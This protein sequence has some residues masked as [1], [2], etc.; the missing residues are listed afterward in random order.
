VILKQQHPIHDVQREMLRCTQTVPRRQSRCG[1][2]CRRCRTPPWAGQQ[3]AHATP[4]PG[5]HFRCCNRLL[6]AVSA[7]DKHRPACPQC[8]QMHTVPLTHTQDCVPW[9][10]AP[11]RTWRETGPGKT[12]NAWVLAKWVVSKCRHTTNTVGYIVQVK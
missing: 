12:W 10:T 6:F 1:C 7:V 3:H 8:T 4:V 11:H 2:G 5:V 9:V